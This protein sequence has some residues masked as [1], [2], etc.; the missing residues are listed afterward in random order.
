MY[1]SDKIF[2]IALLAVGFYFLYQGEVIQRFRDGRTNFAV[3]SE[4]MREM[5]TLSMWMA[6]LPSNFTPGKDFTISFGRHF[7][8]MSKLTFG[9]NSIDGGSLVVEFEQIA[10]WLE[11]SSQNWTSW[12]QIKP[13]KLS[14]QIIPDHVILITFSN[15]TLAH[16]PLSV[17][18]WPTAENNTLLDCQSKY[19][20]GEITNAVTANPGEQFWLNIR[21]KKFIYLDKYKACRKKPYMKE[22]IARFDRYISEKL[23]M[24][25]SK[26]CRPELIYSTCTAM[27][28]SDK[29]RNLRLCRSRKDEIDFYEAVDYISKTITKLPCT[30]VT[31]HMG[32]SGPWPIV[33]KYRILFQF[34][35]QNPY[36]IEVNEEYFI[37]DL[38]GF[39]GSI[40]GTLGLCIGFSFKDLFRDIAS[41]VVQAVSR[42]IQ[43]KKE[44]ETQTKSQ[45]QKT[46]QL[47]LETQNLDKI[48]TQGDLVLP[49]FAK[50]TELETKLEKRLS[51]H[52]SRLLKME[53]KLI[54]QSS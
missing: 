36:E 30:K 35:M 46:G 6:N 9:H 13:L 53:E 26:I 43:H 40:G 25:N 33:D 23:V 17:H 12:F 18:I 22:F 42:I 51:D 52:D 32:T 15:I 54:G 24:K 5:A 14:P 34:T 1:I 49:I 47:Q 48:S 27:Y 44:R 21:P 7:G 50:L 37:L 45:S 39:I 29:V 16:K 31:Y 11:K 38:V 20:D 3:Y 28:T 10:V 2:H 41:S 19:Y 8:N 4:P